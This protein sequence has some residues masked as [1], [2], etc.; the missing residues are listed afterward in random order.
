MYCGDQQCNF[1]L[2]C[3]HCQDWSPNHWARIQIYTFLA[4]QREKKKR[5]EGSLLVIILIFFRFLVLILKVDYLLE[6][7]PS[8]LQWI[9][10]PTYYFQLSHDIIVTSISATA[11]T[12]QLFTSQL[13]AIDSF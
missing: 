1:D 11:I 13:L 8:G 9:G 2:C 4:E 12:M 7:G 6:P 3:N 5:K 10:P